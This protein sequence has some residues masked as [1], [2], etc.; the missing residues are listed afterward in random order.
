[1]ASPTGPGWLLPI[2]DRNH[3]AAAHPL[4]KSDCP[5]RSFV[6]PRRDTQREGNPTATANHTL[7]SLGPYVTDERLEAA[8]DSA[9]VGGLTS[10]E[11]L[12]KRLVQMSSHHRGTA[13]L[14]RLLDIR[15]NGQAPTDSELERMYHRKITV[16]HSLPTP[17]FQFPI[18]IPRKRR[19]DFAYP[20]IWLGVEV[21]GWKAHGAFGKWMKDFDRHNELS[22]LGWEIL[23]FP[24][25]AV[26][27]HSNRV[28]AQVKEAI[29][30]RE[31]SLLD[32]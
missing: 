18:E 1:M 5:P 30:R 12:A 8:L 32:K 4:G 6:S 25:T 2:L 3:V 20:H 26:L 15:L 23:Y 14:R 27:E 7:I 16:V 11:Y 24:W 22:A 29:Q 19:I 31:H 9:L 17:I 10:P 21:L 28:A 13:E